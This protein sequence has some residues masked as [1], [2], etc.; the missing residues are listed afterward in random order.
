LFKRYLP[1]LQ[2]IEIKYG[3]REFEMR[4]NFYYRNFLR[5]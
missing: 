4:N 5:F 2:K 3:W 1:S